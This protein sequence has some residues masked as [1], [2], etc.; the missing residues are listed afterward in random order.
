MTDR[1][2][3]R[4]YRADDDGR[5]SPQGAPRSDSDPLA[6]LARLI[7]QTDPFGTSAPRQAPPQTPAPYPAATH[8]RATDFR[9]S[10][11]VPP[12][13]DDVE[14]APPSQPS[15]LQRR[16]EAPRDN[17]P[18]EP[19]FS[20]PPS[21]VK[22]V[23]PPVDQQSD[24]RAYNPGPMDFTPSAAPANYEP[25]P[26]EQ[27]ALD[28]REPVFDP[29]SFEAQ[30][31]D[32][33]AAAPTSLEPNRYDEALFGELPP[34]PQP[35]YY[36]DQQYGYDDGYADEA[37]AAKPRRS[38]MMTVVSILA[39]AVVGTGGAFAYR[40]FVGGHRSGEPP[41]IKAD[42]SPTKVPGPAADGKPIQDR[43][44]SNGTEALVSREE[45]PADPSQSQNGPRVVLPQLNQNPN[46]P[47]VAST[48]PS[49]RPV[50]PPPQT[51]ASADEPRRIKTFSIHPDQADPAAEPVGRTPPATRPASRA[52]APAAAAPAQPVV[53]A[54]R[55]R[56][57]E[58]ANASAGNA[59]MSLSPDAD[60][61]RQTNQRVAALTPAESAGGG[62]YLVQV[63][64]QLSESEAKSS[65]RVLQGKF[66]SVLGSRS[67]V[68][69]R[70]DVGGKT[71]YRAMVGPFSASSEAQQFCG[72]LKS[73]G[74]QCFVQRN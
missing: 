39:L 26:V 5:T 23:A 35:G 14:E 42:T 20:R 33:R 21:F 56:S 46:P 1:T 37:P 67:P 55:G 9:M 27:P 22:A 18:I 60:A 12:V 74:G 10:R 69:K 57:V 45:Q 32:P 15:W 17:A 53:Q 66:P 19:D 16:R 48:S 47:G 59:P 7:G 44:A 34:E 58:D 65:Y 6:E 62:N 64:S 13:P 73:A 38:G 11:P 49:A 36:T 70:A 41:V 68:I 51:T 3:E 40:T 43:L 4:A 30:G 8:S 63:S 24:M 2:Y 71:V 28:L 31:Y 54:R 25:V 52:P 72:S 61:P 50:F 29:R